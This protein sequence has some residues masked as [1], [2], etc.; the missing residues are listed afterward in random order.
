MNPRIVPIRNGEKGPR[1]KGWPD[2]TH[3]VSDLCDD[4]GNFDCDDHDAYGIVLDEDMI[5]VDV[6]QH[7]GQHNGFESL[8][9]I[10]DDVG[11][12]LMA[13]AVF[14]LGAIVP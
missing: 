13:E 3:R 1:I 11:L 14:N 7:D 6:D 2:V 12:D 8:E 10:K 5:I 4:G 9:A